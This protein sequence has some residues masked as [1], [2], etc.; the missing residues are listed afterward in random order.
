MSLFC[1]YS[2]LVHPPRVVAVPIPKD[3]T[4]P[5]SFGHPALPRNAISRV[6]P[7]RKRSRMRMRFG[8]WERL[9][10][11]FLADFGAQKKT[12]GEAPMSHPCFHV[13]Y[14]S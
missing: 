12:V 5:W 10:Y 2:N 6:R 9:G 4:I 3:Y 8:A 7:P 14:H 1:V 11:S 13:R